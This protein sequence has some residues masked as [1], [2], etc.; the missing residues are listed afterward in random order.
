MKIIK[1][2]SGDMNNIPVQII[3]GENAVPCGAIY[4]T[5]KILNVFYDILGQERVNIKNI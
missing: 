2:F 5:D 4:C 3:E 1:Y